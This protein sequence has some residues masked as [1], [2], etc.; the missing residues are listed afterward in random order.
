MKER[1][2]TLER[3]YKLLKKMSDNAYS[4][5]QSESSSLQF[6]ADE[7]RAY[8]S[9]EEIIRLIDNIDLFEEIENIFNKEG[10]SNGLQ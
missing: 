9:Y 1:K 7:F 6:R 4:L 3:L 5:S 2:V 10:E 8:M